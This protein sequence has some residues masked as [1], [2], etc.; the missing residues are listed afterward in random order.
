VRLEGGNAKTLLVVEEEVDLGGKKV[1][2]IHERVYA[3]DQRGV[4]E[5]E[6]DLFFIESGTLEPSVS[7]LTTCQIFSDINP[8]P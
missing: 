8:P 1:A 5:K 6:C 4:S 3:L 7:G 2:M